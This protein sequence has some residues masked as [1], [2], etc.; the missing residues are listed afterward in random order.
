MNF[1]L[2]LLTDEFIFGFAAKWRF[3]K[4][5]WFVALYCLCFCVLVYHINAPKV[6]GPKVTHHEIPVTKV[7][8]SNSPI[9]KPTKAYADGH[10]KPKR[11]RYHKKGDPA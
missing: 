8:V 9:T 1:K 4:D 5:G 7:E 10:Q 2:A 6:E 11:R 3:S